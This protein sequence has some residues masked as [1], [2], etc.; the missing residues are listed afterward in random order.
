M[1]LGSDKPQADN[2]IVSL[3]PDAV[4]DSSQAECN[5]ISTQEQ[6]PQRIASLANYKI[7]IGFGHSHGDGSCVT[8]RI[9]GQ[10]S[11]LEDIS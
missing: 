6:L 9:D 1:R 2:H 4:P 7:Q 11:I 8:R 3:L 10:I 5:A